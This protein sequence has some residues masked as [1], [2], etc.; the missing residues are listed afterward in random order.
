MVDDDQ[1]LT[2]GLNGT[3]TKQNIGF[4]VLC[5]MQGFCVSGVSVATAFPLNS[6]K[7]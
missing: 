6:S 3:N 7:A 2:C 5:Q 1:T 4:I